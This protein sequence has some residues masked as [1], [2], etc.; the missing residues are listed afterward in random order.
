MPP[1]SLGFLLL[2]GDLLAEILDGGGDPLD[3]A[4]AGRRLLQGADLLGDGGL[5]G[6]EIVGELDELAT[7]D[8]ADAC[9]QDEREGHG[10]EHRG[11]ARQLEASEPVDQRR[12]CEAQEDGQAKG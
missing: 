3:D 4:A 5:V 10:N 9:D 8:E 7:D 6:R 2:A 12:K 11:D 1:A